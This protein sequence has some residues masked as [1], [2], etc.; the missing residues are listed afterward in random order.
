MG[1]RHA[2][3]PR[4]PERLIDRVLLECG[5]VAVQHGSPRARDITPAEWLAILAEEVGEVAREVQTGDHARM[6]EELVQVAATALNM[7]EA[8][9]RT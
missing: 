5:R 6:I 3:S 2:A 7:A 9:R 4:P 8:A 1:T